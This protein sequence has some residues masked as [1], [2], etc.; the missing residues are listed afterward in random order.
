MAPKLVL[1]WG[2]SQRSQLRQAN[3]SELTSSLSRVCAEEQA[4]NTCQKSQDTCTASK[5][6]KEKKKK[7]T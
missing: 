1:E 3:A 4:Q 6:K 5:K 2:A 7:E